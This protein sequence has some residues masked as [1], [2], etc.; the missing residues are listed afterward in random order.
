MK[1]IIQ[2]LDKN[3]IFIPKESPTGF[4]H[5]RDFMLNIFDKLK[6][7]DF[8]DTILFIIRADK[9]DRLTDIYINNKIKVMNRLNI[10]T[11]QIFVDFPNSYEN[12]KEE[13]IKSIN[14]CNDIIN[15]S[16]DELGIKFN[17]MYFML[18]KDYS[19]MSN[20]YKDIYSTLVDKLLSREDKIYDVEL[21]ETFGTPFFKYCDNPNIND[22]LIGPCT[23]IGSVNMLI[24]NDKIKAG[25]NVLVYGR[26]DILGYPL[27]CILTKIGCTLTWF[28]SRSEEKNYLNTF[29]NINNVF[30]CMDYKNFINE[31]QI[32][33]YSDNVNII[34]FGI[35]VEN[36]DG[37]NKVSGNINEN[38]F[39]LYK[40]KKNI[41]TP[42]PCGTAYTTLIQICLNIYIMNKILKGEL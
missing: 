35:T 36:I 29:K 27:G 23:P 34:D 42:T 14:Q 41:I 21:L 40:D 11:I 25:D 24:H 15:K 31:E 13:I 5:C 38:I 30:L 39:E 28:N 17:N 37:K 6:D 22:Y 2:E 18:Q 32:K 33:K 10:R 4:N 3:N 26:S 16:L 8:T 19:F 7:E 12:L 9:E 1:Y 20:V